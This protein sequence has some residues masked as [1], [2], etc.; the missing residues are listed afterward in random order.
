M[1]GQASGVATNPLAPRNSTRLTRLEDEG[2]RDLHISTVARGLDALTGADERADD[3]GGGLADFV[4]GTKL[5][6]HDGGKR[7]WSRE[8]R[9]SVKQWVCGLKA[10]PT[11]GLGGEGRGGEGASTRT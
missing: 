9:E 11:E 2:A 1:R 8:R 4:E 3:K 6:P 5:D 7:D 10:E